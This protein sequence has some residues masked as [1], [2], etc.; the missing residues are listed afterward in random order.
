MSITLRAG[1]KVRTCTPVLSSDHEGRGGHSLWAQQKGSLQKSL[2]E[3]GHPCGLR[4][5]SSTS[6]LVSVP[7]AHQPHSREFGG[8]HR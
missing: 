2:R 6:P 5:A 3:K 8:M 4:G 1:S 7:G